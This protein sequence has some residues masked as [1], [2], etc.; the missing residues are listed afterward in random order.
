MIFLDAENPARKVTLH[1]NVPDAA[2]RLAER[3]DD[4]ID[5]DD[6][7][8]ETLA[9]GKQWQL[10][11]RIASAE[12]VS[13]ELYKTA[14]ALARHRNLIEAGDDLAARRRA[15]ADEVADSV[16]RVQV[17]ADL[18]EAAGQGGGGR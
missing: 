16:R 1:E 7:L 10:Q 2:E 8:E 12:S 17:I 11:R 9:V 4:P 18:A 5:E 14:L 15:F 6:L 3:G 13:L